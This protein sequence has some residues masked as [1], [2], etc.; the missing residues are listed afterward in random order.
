MNSLSN[1]V[2]DKCA[3]YSKSEYPEGGD[4]VDK[5]FKLLCSKEND[6]VRSRTLTLLGRNVLFNKTCGQVLDTTF[7]EVC[8]RVSYP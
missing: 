8:D 7:A 4:P 1:C 6:V 3:C 2:A 5:V